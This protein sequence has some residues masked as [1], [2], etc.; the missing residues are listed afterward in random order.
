MDRRT[1]RRSVEL[2]LCD[3]NPALDGG[4]F[5]DSHSLQRARDL[6]LDERVTWLEQLSMPLQ[7]AGIRTQVE[8]QWG[9]PLDRDGP[10][11]GRRNRPDLVLKSTASTTCCAACYWATATGN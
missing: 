5:F 1:Q 4:L 2:L 9:K 7:Q 11:T 8:A 6:Y 3:F 10:A